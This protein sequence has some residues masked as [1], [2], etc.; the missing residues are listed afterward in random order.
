MSWRCAD[1]ICTWCR[2]PDSC[3]DSDVPLACWRGQLLP[4]NGPCASLVQHAFVAAGAA[5]LLHGSFTSMWRLSHLRQ[6]V[7]RPQVGLLSMRCVVVT[8]GVCS[9]WSHK[10]LNQAHRNRSCGYLSG[11]S[12]LLSFACA[13]GVFRRAVVRV[14][15]FGVCR[16]V[17]SGSSCRQINAMGRC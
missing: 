17:L 2:T 9:T 1:S 14:H 11:G 15:V 5:A 8:P 10:A 13:V 3:V 16:C 12:A 6:T 7:H 4:G